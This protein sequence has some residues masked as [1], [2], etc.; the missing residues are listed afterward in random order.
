MFACQIHVKWSVFFNDHRQRCDS[1]HTFILKTPNNHQQYRP[2]AMSHNL[3]TNREPSQQQ[4][5]PGGTLVVLV[6]RRL[7][8]HE[9]D[10]NE[11]Q[12]QPFALTM[13]QWLHFYRHSS[14]SAHA[15]HSMIPPPA[16]SDWSICRGM[17]WG[18]GLTFGSSIGV[19]PW[20]QI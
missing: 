14:Y 2:S 19:P 15:V 12:I 3:L 11:T 7:P 5:S 6:S 9:R 13:K 1:S 10:M 18:R 20:R 4:G 8:Q 16:V 17:N